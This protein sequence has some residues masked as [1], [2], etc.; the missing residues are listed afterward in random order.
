[1]QNPYQPPESAI[2][3]ELARQ[4]PASLEV[5]RGPLVLPEQ[6][7]KGYLID[8]AAVSMLSNLELL[9]YAVP[10]IDNPSVIFG[11]LK[12]SNERTSFCYSGI[13]L[14]YS[15]TGHCLIATAKR[16][17]DD[18]IYITLLALRIEDPSCPGYPVGHEKDFGE[19]LW[20]RSR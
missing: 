17:D 11:N 7:A 19:V 14:D 4:P 10:L 2:P 9:S 13:P 15:R 3:I 6:G 8:C 5:G 1:M 12:R 16:C 20:K 18:Y